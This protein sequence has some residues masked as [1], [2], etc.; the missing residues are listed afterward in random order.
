MSRRISSFSVLLVMAVLSVIGIA[1]LPMLNIQYKPSLP[2]RTITVSFSYPGAS[3]EIV[4]AE[5]T[6]KIEGIMARLTGC[7]GTSSVSS[8]GY[9]SA[10]V[11][12]SKR[13]DMASARLELASAI[14][15]IYPELPDGV[16]YPSI[17]HNAQGQRSSTAI[18]YLIKGSLPSQEIEKYVREHVM[19]EISAVKGVDNVSL[20][21]ATPYHW[22]ITFDAAKTASAG[23][24]PSD[25]AEAFR[26][27]YSETLIGL[28][29]VGNETM[30]VRL[31]S[32]NEG[33]DFGSI[34]V[35]NSEGRIVHLRD[36]AHW[37]YQESLP[38]SYYRVNG[39]NTI[40][41]SVGV[42]GDV[43][44][45][46]VTEDV[47][48]TMLEL[49]RGF[50]EEITAGI[51]Y[52]SSEY[53]SGELDK[54]YLRTGLCILILLLFVFVVS[55]SW[56]YMLIIVLTLAVNLLIALA[57]YAFAGISIHIYTLAGIT[58]SLGIVIDTSIVMIDHYAHFRDRKAFPSLVAAVGTTI[59]ALLMVLLLPES[60]KANLKDFIWVISLNLA[61]SLVVS[62]LFIPALMDY[63]P[64]QTSASVSSMRKRRRQARRAGRYGRY[65]GWGLR[66]R[67]VYVVVFILAFGLPLCVLP[68]AAQ[69]EKKNDKNLWQ[70]GVEKVV[71]WRPYADN[72][73]TIDKI[74][75]SSFGAFY[76][77][78]GRSNFYREPQQKTLHIN[79]GMLEGCTVHQLNEV[80]KSMENYLAGFD[81]IKVF[82]TDVSSY[83][84]ASITVEFKPEYENTAFPSQ[85]KAL[86]TSMAIN[87]GGANWSIYGIDDNGFN[88]NIVTNYKSHRITLKGYNYQEL[89]RYAEYL[90]EHLSQNR[91]VSGA[92][93]WGAGWNGRP[94]TE[95]N[96]EYDFERMAVADIN[97]YQYYSAL[98]S[99]LYDSP[100]SSV[101]T[102]GEMTEVVLR[103]SEIEKYDY[104]HVLHTPVSTGDVAAPLQDIGSIEKRLSGVSISKSHQSYEINVCFDFIG[105]YELSKRVIDKAVE[106]M[107]DE[108][109]PIG[110]KA[111]NPQGGW[112]DENKDKYAW[113]IFLIVAVIFVVLAMTFE[114]LRLPLAVIFMI[115]IS[116]IGLFLTFGLSDLSFDQGGFA[117]FVMLCGIVVNAGIYIVLTYKDVIQHNPELTGIRGYVKAFGRK[118]NPIMLT[119]IST[120][121]GLI[122]F[123]TDGPQEVF[124]FDFAIGTIGGMVFSVIAVI[125]VLPVFVLRSKKRKNEYHV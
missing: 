22:V 10:S 98:A 111:H 20:Y 68:T 16:S 91:R 113:L 125:L 79:A 97:P 87:F 58:V 86:V 46:T 29:D 12:L 122:P 42:A 102:E 41:L 117:A 59:A 116:F 62:W 40:T 93:V 71:S 81:E 55:R 67:W 31:A 107:N 104:W 56:R 115:P 43:N 28:S 30:A 36:V 77:A 21:G 103:S 57:I 82:T 66:H 51:A 18:S 106:H 78:L 7:T 124:W 3:P 1:T 73:Q 45:L 47:R 54:I 24:S 114:S 63:L 83:S 50:P 80:V 90:V 110:Y 2:G 25:I 13:T 101:N 74:A 5:V 52:D 123:L 94:K 120:V 9:G 118:I 64:V 92:E 69:M 119:V 105:S 72:R 4:E 53:V 121:L 88:N 84:N 76:R 100:I 108:I 89:K 44:L 95:F 6:S 49:Q 109:L 37:K 14:R 27:A 34:P 96:M 48:E 15:N 33:D 38:G 85:L 65:I 17:S 11:N 8:L 70:K 32:M 61:V 39:L 23:V 26:S 35:K 99:Q 75:G 112:W 19:P 60:E